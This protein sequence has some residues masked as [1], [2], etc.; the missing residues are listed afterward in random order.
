MTGMGRDGARRIGD[1]Y[2]A[3][4]MTIAQNEKSSVVYGMPRVAYEYGY[5]HE[6]VDLSEMASTLSKLVKESHAN[7]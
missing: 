2:E 7:G 6:L 4:G 1:I 5:I 3:G